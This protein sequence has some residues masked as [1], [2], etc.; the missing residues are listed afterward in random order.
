MSTYDEIIHRR[1]QA[2]ALYLKLWSLGLDVRAERCAVGAVGRRVMVEGLRSLNPDH[3]DRLMRLV[4]DNEAGL[5]EILSNKRNPDL[6]A[7][8]PKRSSV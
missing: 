3:A 2:H 6:A 7:N 1:R 8:H 5:L 4:R